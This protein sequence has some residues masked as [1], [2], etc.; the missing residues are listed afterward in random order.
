VNPSLALETL[1]RL[2]Q[3]D[4]EDVRAATSKNPNISQIS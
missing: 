1:K 3:D 4:N 2:T